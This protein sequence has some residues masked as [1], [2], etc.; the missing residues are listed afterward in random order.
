MLGLML[1]YAT[2]K[3]RIDCEQWHLQGTALVII[4]SFQLVPATLQLDESASCLQRW[5]ER[6]HLDMQKA[7][8][9]LRLQW[10]GNYMLHV[11][12]DSRVHSNVTLLLEMRR[13]ISMRQGLRNIRLTVRKLPS[14]NKNNYPLLQQTKHTL[15]RLS[16]AP[17]PFDSS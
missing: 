7:T 13:P 12:G 16:R 1:P 17:N 5:V 9:R 3:I 15:P 11:R 8:L 6:H 10:L 14:F 2:V 4:Q